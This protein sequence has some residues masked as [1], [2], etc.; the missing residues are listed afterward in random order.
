MDKIKQY[1][2]YIKEILIKN[3]PISYAEEYEEYEV[4]II[5]DYENNHFYLMRLGWDNLKRF[6]YC[7]IHV[8]IK[9]TGKIWIQEDNTEYSVANELIDKGVPKSDIVLAYQAPY[10]RKFSEFSIT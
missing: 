8:D 6:H 4:Q 7:V 9:S 1:Q 5:T 3:A 10:R 2:Q